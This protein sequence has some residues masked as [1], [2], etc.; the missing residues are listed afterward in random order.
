M[1]VR[2]IAAGHAY[3]ETSPVW[4]QRSRKAKRLGNARRGTVAGANRR[5]VNTHTG[6]M[7]NHA[8]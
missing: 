2:A 5:A 7:A 8:Q 3:R 6:A 1:I 4:W